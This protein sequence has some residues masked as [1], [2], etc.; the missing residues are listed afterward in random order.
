[1]QPGL[2][3]I[4]NKAISREMTDMS[5]DKLDDNALGILARELGLGK[6]YAENPGLVRR[7]YDSAR[8]MA[9]RLPRPDDIADEPSH[10]FQANN[11]V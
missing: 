4:D 6:L 7:A 5:D 11:N 3:R 9:E 10:I 1:M 8:A 2:P